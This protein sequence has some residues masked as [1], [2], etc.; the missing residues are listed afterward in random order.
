M[1]RRYV[2]R[3]GQWRRPGR[4]NLELE[5][6]LIVCMFISMNSQVNLW[7][8]TVP[9]A[10][11]GGVCGGCDGG[12]STGGGCGG[13]SVGGGSS[14]SSSLSSQSSHSI[15]LPSTSVRLSSG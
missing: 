12:R 4:C 3:G 14:S 1:K 11:V 6:G 2:A 5:F 13:G 15:S 8:F 10:E 9:S 7:M